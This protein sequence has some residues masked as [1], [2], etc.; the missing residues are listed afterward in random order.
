M[1]QLKIG[2]VALLASALCVMALV[3]CDADNNEGNADGEFHYSNGIDENG[4][5]K[6]ITAKDYVELPDYDN[7]VIPTAS[8]QVTDDELQTQIDSILTS[9]STSE[10]VTDRAVEDGDTVNI[11]FVGSVDGVEFDGGN[12]N[13]QG[14]DVTIGVTEYIDGF[15]EQLI[16]HSPGENFDINVTFPEN[17]GRNLDG[18]DAV[19]NITIN[20]ILDS[21]KPELTDEFVAENMQENYGWTTVDE[22]EVDLRANI[23]QNA[24]S[25]YI[26]EYLSGIPV[27]DVPQSV[28]DYQ[29]S[30]LV[31]Y[32]KAS[33]EAQNVSLDDFLANQVGVSN[34][35]DLIEQSQENLTKT[36]NLQLVIQAIAEDASISVS[37][38]DV[39]DYFTEFY[40]GAS[41]KDYESE[42]GLPYLKMMVLSQTVI[43][44]VTEN[45]TLE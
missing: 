9:F 7:I 44:R 10:Q 14:E 8:H 18:K 37:E 6:G 5:W 16:G 41:Y 11:D 40:G 45:A 19:F 39:S 3:G 23:Q 20:Y 29:E 30:A 27:S 24:V 2:L 35:E 31:D 38:E 1:K 22:M 28:L 13:G 4:F 17:Y 36:A 34:V 25:N 12:T 42:F 21:T 15:L 43:E 32:Y 33:A 26:E